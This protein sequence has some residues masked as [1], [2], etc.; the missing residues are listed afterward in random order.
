MAREYNDVQLDVTFTAASARE[1]I[2]SAEN[3]ALSFGKLA[4]WYTDF[5][6]SAFTAPTVAVTG[7]GNAITSA[8]YGTGANANKLT[9]TKGSTFLTQHPTIPTQTDETSTASPAFGGTFTSVDSVTRDSNGHVLKIN[10]KTVTIPNATM[11]AATADTAGTIGLVPAPAAGKQSSFLRGDGTWVVPTNTDTKVTQNVSDE[12]KKFPVLLSYYENTDNTTTAQTVNRVNTIY[13][14]PNSGYLWTK[15]LQSPTWGIAPTSSAPSSASFTLSDTGLYFRSRYLS[16]DGNAYDYSRP[17]L[18]TYKG[19]H[20]NNGMVVSLDSGG[21]TIVGG[22]ESATSLAGLISEDQHSTSTTP[23]KLDVGGTLGTTFTG[24][25]EQ[26]LLSSD[27]NIYFITKCNTIAQRQPV[28][29]DTSLQFYPGTNETGSI[30]TSSYKWGSIYAKNIYVNKIFPDSGVY[31]NNNSGFASAPWA[32]TVDFRCTSASATRWYAFRVY[33]GYEGTTIGS[34]LLIIEITTTADKVYSSGKVVWV[35]AA[36]SLDKDNFAVTYTD[37]A[38]TSTT[39]AIWAKCTKRYQSWHV[40]PLYG[41]WGSGR[42]DIGINCYSTTT[43]EAAYTGTLIASEY[44]DIKNNAASADKINTNAGSATQPVYFSNGVPVTV[45]QAASGAWFGIV[46]YVRSNDGGMEIGR[47]IDFHNTSSSTADYNIRLDNASTTSLRFSELNATAGANFSPAT[48]NKYDLGTSSLKWRNIY[49]TTFYGDLNGTINTATTATTQ[50]KGD[51]S[52]KVATTAFVQTAIGD[53]IPLAGSDAISGSLKF[54]AIQKGVYLKDSAGTV[55]AGIYYNGSNFWIGSEKAATAHFT[56]ATMISAGYDSSSSK[57][58]LTIKVYTVNAANTGATGRDVFHNANLFAGTGLT[59]ATAAST[60]Y[61]GTIYTINHSNSVTA[62]TVGDQSAK[63]LTWSD[64]FKVP[65]VVYDTEG[66]ITTG[67]TDIT[68]TM[69]ANPNTDENVKITKLGASTSAAN[70]LG[71]FVASAGTKGLN[72]IDTFGLRH[73]PGTTSAVGNT[74]ILLGNG[75]AEGTVNNEEGYLLLYS[76]GSGYNVLRAK[77]SNSNFNNYLPAATG[78]LLNDVT[79][80]GKD[81]HIL[82]PAD[83]TYTA[84][85][86]NITGAFV[87]TLP[88]GM[89]SIMLS[90]TVDI[91]NYVTGTT[92]SYR[93]AGYNY[94]SDNKWYN[95]SAIC[96]GDPLKMT[97]TSNLTV[98]FGYNGTKAQVQ[99]GETN[100]AWKWPNV[101]VRNIMLGYTSDADKTFATNATGWTV[102]VV[103]TDISNV[104][105]TITNTNMSMFTKTLATYYNEDSGFASAPW[106][107]IAERVETSASAHRNIAFFVTQGYTASGTYPYW[108]I[109]VI[110]YKTSSSKVFDSGNVEW[111]VAHEKLN[112]DDIAV[113][114]TNVASTSTTIQIWTKTTARYCGY[115]F[116]SLTGAGFNLGSDFAPWTFYKPTSGVAAYTGT[117]ITS[118]YS[119][120]KNNAISATTAE[121]ISTDAGNANTPVYFSGGIPVAVTLPTSGA[122]WTSEPHID[123]SGVLEVG[124]YIDFHA[125]NASTNNYDVRLDASSTSL[126]TLSSV[127]GTPA[128]RISGTLPRLRF[129]QTTTGKAY[130]NAGVGIW[131]Q[132]ADTNGV[133]MF[134]QSHGNMMISSGEFCANA[135]SRKDSTGQT[136]VGY[137]NIVGSTLEKLYLGSDSEVQI[138]SNGQNINTYSNND[139]KVWKFGTD[140]TLLDPNGLVVT[141]MDKNSTSYWGMF[142]GDGVSN[143]WIRTT[144]YG[145]IPYQSGGLTSPHSALGTSTWSYSD[146]WSQNIHSVSLNVYNSGATYKHTI[147]SAAAAA[148]KTIEIPNYSG[149]VMVTGIGDALTSANSIDADTKDITKHWYVVNGAT[150]GQIS[151]SPAGSNYGYHIFNIPTTAADN[152]YQ[153]QLLFGNTSDIPY[154][155]RY[156]RN[157]TWSGGWRSPGTGFF[158]VVGTHTEATKMWTGALQIPALYDGLTIAFYVPFPSASST[159]TDVGDT[160]ANSNVWLKLTL[161]NGTT[162]DWIPVFWN[163]TTRMTGHHGAGSTVILTYWSAPNIAGTTSSARWTKADYNASTVTQN[164]LA[165]TTNKNYPL[166]MSYYEVGVTTTSAQSVRR[167]QAIYANASTGT[168][169]A[170]T[171]NGAATKLS[172]DAGSEIRP[173]YFTDGVPTRCAATY[174]S[175]TGSGYNSSK[176]YYKIAETIDIETAN[177]QYRICFLVSRRKT[178]DSTMDASYGILCVHFESGSSNGSFG[179]GSA[180]WLAVENDFDISNVN[181]RRTTGTN[182]F[183]IALWFKLSNANDVVIVQSFDV[184]GFSYAANSKVWSFISNPTADTYYVGTEIAATIP[185]LQNYAGGGQKLLYNGSITISGTGNQLAIANLDH[186]QTLLVEVWHGT[187][188]KSFRFICPVQYV[189]AQTDPLVAF[190]TSDQLTSSDLSSGSVK[191]GITTTSITLLILISGYSGTTATVRIYS[192]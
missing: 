51:N 98:R 99:I 138:I 103:T 106:A 157:G 191:V 65:K 135:Y 96:I 136:Q 43:G 141:G 187:A 35:Y 182:K 41:G 164:I 178:G 162:T 85:S 149:T 137:D 38:S 132:P 144:T 46:P 140:G 44:A 118:S 68:I 133:N 159:N 172:T 16:E 9:L 59:F 12:D 78:T 122:W 63:T 4:K 110:K 111:L 129:S 52:T 60:D 54:N 79:G 72:I 57:G 152:K 1:N 53:Y 109:L 30:G 142:D 86:Q 50:T 153:K 62:G 108:G 40:V 160:S 104:T 66:H 123:G 116:C 48:N 27:N 113:T 67:T 189:L 7:S 15:A 36:G 163:S 117:L 24:S 125:T 33:Q 155:Y 11:G 167:A 124:R 39:I 127:S 32:K 146:V 13:A 81:G 119:T 169:T 94:S 76:P 145:F 175:L 173:V 8:S 151:D 126:L 166:L 192:I 183:K 180:K 55:F 121:S 42:G 93:V 128:L 188:G 6:W 91:Y 130:D 5:A 3:I 100:T 17:V 58:N 26:L 20:D 88:F 156:L 74:R 105:A 19:K 165:T 171:F 185:T 71:T 181:L 69:P 190:Q 18:R 22:G 131:C 83:G 186:Y 90:F 49:A 139:H 184:L 77:K 174:G 2:I 112:K 101:R 28:V 115:V 114:Y 177:T 158:Y 154:M 161:S 29:L 170:T 45:T 10:T 87:V 176:P 143:K 64:T 84:Q 82:T 56:G 89:N 168:I 179:R 147:T 97:S 34:G 134:M 92:V 37:T 73:T 21:L 148:N 80:V 102:S 150:S 75:T 14:N 25:A 61:N 95:C 31:Y 23:T 70:Y 107:K 120:L 47:F